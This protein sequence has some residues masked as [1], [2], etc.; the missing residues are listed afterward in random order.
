MN[1]T[2]QNV[3]GRSSGYKSPVLEILTIVPE[4]AIMAVS[5]LPAYNNSSNHLE[6]YTQVENEFDNF[7]I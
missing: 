6:G 3:G 5:F 7:W 2:I 1:R 4:T